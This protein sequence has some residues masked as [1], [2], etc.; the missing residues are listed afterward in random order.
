MLKTVCTIVITVS[1]I[2]LFLAMIVGII[3]K[4]VRLFRSAP[5]DLELN[6]DDKGDNKNG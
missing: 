3:T 2:I 5:A 1:L 6:N 4:L